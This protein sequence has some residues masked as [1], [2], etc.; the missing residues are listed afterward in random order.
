VA[1]TPPNKTLRI[2]VVANKYYE[3]D[4]L[5]VALCNELA[6]SPRLGIPIISRGHVCRR[7]KAV[8]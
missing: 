4:G 2:V 5:M 6:R 7:R 3:G 8:R 1:Q